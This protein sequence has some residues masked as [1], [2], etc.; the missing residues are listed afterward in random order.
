MGFADEAR[1]ASAANVEREF[2]SSWK[3]SIRAKPLQR[4]NAGSD[5][6]AGSYQTSK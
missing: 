1:R 2:R 3:M 5:Q 6:F 4:F